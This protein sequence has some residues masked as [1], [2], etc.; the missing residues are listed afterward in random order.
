MSR[1]AVRESA[2]PGTAYCGY[3][4]VRSRSLRADSGSGKHPPIFGTMSA[5]ARRQPN[6]TLHG[7]RP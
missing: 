5:E 2:I 7:V 6:E 3:P 4:S 1:C